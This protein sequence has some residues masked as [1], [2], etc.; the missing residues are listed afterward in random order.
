MRSRGRS[1]AMFACAAL[2]CGCGGFERGE[3]S[4]DAGCEAAID[5]MFA[6]EVHPILLDRCSAC[7]G[8]S[9]ATAFALSG[10]AASDRD[11]ALAFA[12]LAA[13]ER[14][15]LLAKARGDGHGGGEALSASSPDYATVLAWLRGDAQVQLAGCDM[16]AG[17]GGGGTVPD[18]TVD[19]A[20]PDAGREPDAGPVD[21]TVEDGGPLPDAA[22]G[23]D[24]ETEVHPL[25]LSVC[26]PCHAAGGGG[27]Q[28]RLSLTGD[29]ADDYAT[30][31]A[32]VDV[33]DAQQS[34]LLTKAR[35]VAHAAGER[36]ATDSIEYALLAEWI[37][38]GALP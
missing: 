7:H 35:G 24:F 37:E 36:F 8:A 5:A 31:V 18:A 22:T 14:S 25:L 9:S 27:G 38:A 17:T 11:V 28:T 21:A 2:A 34:L 12:D 3:A 13:P 26:V 33:D 23:P 6:A 1:A 4:P 29:A 30:V 16:D 20:P 10:D 19:A 32:L 15:P